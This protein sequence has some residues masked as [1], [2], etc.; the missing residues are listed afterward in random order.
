MRSAASSVTLAVGLGLV[1]ALACGCAG[2]GA[3]GGP[4]T[5][6]GGGGST[7]VTA[8]AVATDFAARDLEGKT[9]KLT[10]YLGKQAILIDFWATYCEP[11]LAEMPSLRKVYEKHKA[12]GFVVLAVS[13]DGPE[14]IADVPSFAK[15][16]T[17][18][19]PV[20]LDEDSRIT[21]IYNPKKSAPL[22]V[23]IDKAG[24]IVRV[25]EGYNPGDDA[26]TEAAVA[27]VLDPGAP[28]K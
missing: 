22:S 7:S 6:G 16:N 4:S 20:L 25:H 15:R 14:T 17:M 11:C 10:D 3:A 13:V 23:L 27:N 9:V 12:Q 28:A 18:T 21:S 24:K 26:E 1:G 8:G 2:G 5:P 19:F